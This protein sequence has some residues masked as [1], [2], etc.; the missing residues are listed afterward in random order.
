MDTLLSRFKE[1]HR[2]NEFP[3]VCV[4]K[5]KKRAGSHVSLWSDRGWWGASSGLDDL[6]RSAY[7]CAHRQ[8]SG[9]CRP[10]LTSQHSAA[11]SHTGIC[12]PSHLCKSKNRLDFTVIKRSN[13][14]AY[15]KQIFR[16]SSGCTLKDEWGFWTRAQLRARFQAKGS[17]FF[18]SC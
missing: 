14:T 10:R 1:K 16:F 15:M 9:Y 17:S 13:H 4:Y 8:L 3:C 6:Y 18:L 11:F 12:R 2:T 7:S 5:D